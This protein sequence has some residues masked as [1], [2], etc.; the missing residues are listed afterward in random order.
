MSW[1]NAEAGWYDMHYSLELGILL[2]GGMRRQYRDNQMDLEPGQVWL[3]QMWEPHGFQI[4][5]A[6]CEIVFFEI[7]PPL[8]ASTYFPESKPMNW[9][10]PFTVPPGERPQAA[11]LSARQS[12]LAMARSLRDLQARPDRT[13]SILPRLKLLEVL[14]HL[15]AGWEPGRTAPGAQAHALEMINDAIQQIFSSR[16]RITAQAAARKAGLNRN[17]FSALFAETMGVSYVEFGLRYRISN[18]AEEL[19]S[20][21][22]P[23]KAIAQSWGFT[24]VSH[25]HRCFQLYYQCTPSIY[26]KTAG[27]KTDE[28]RKGAGDKSFSSGK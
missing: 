2:A 11:S 20:T 27:R 7:Y 6:P 4:T 13:P 18:V 8:V 3:C 21:T 16:G 17:A 15:T 10:A 23:L 22:T 25:M 19:R 5:Q 1:P 9:M 28:E 24:D 14:A 26:R 12:L